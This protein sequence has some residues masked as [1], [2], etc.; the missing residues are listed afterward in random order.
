MGFPSSAWDEF[1]EG[2]E[3]GVFHKHIALWELELEVKLLTEDIGTTVTNGTGR[4]DRG[5]VCECLVVRFIIEEGMGEDPRVDSNLFENNDRN[6][7]VLD[8][9]NGVVI[10]GPAEGSGMGVVWDR[11]HG[12]VG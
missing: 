5:V 10:V 8:V 9:S 1:G 6:G 7:V 12:L 11:V 3:R 4:E 2:I